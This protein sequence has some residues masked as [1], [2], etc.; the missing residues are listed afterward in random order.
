MKVA[1]YLGGLNRGGAES[2]ILDICRRKDFA[3]FDFV[4]LYRK[5]GNL[6]EG[7]HETKADVVK[8]SRNGNIIKYVYQLRKFFSKG[9][10]DVVHAQTPSSAMLCM[11]A[12]AFTNT[13]LIVTFHG[14][15]VGMKNW[16]LKWI[17]RHCVNVICVSEY[18]RQFFENRLDLPKMN[19]LRVVYNGIDFSK[20]ETAKSVKKDCI[21]DNGNVKLCMVGSFCTGRSQD[22]IVK[23]MALLK[24]RAK[25]D[26]VEFY[27]IG[28]A[29][30]GEEHEL[31]ACVKLADSYGLAGNVHFL[32]VRNDV[33]ELMK[34]MDGY[35][36][37]TVSDTF[38]ISLIEAMASGLPVLVNDWKV[39]KEV[40]GEWA[41]YF[42]SDDAEDCA[43][44]IE[45]FVENIQEYKENSKRY[46]DEV[47]GKY[48]I[49][50]HLKNIYDIYKS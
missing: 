7:F 47:I 16:Y 9:K 28:G 8:L 17:Y 33:Y 10:F 11:F 27:F 13:K 44:A 42:K 30:K 40:C 3:P 24:E 43:N 1:Y 18:E 25:C 38:G 46:I 20:I 5:E 6:S 19:K 15:Y 14:H 36:Y 39:M 32:G 22:V 48:S 26:N 4:C 23:S 37:S 50:R 45:N 21:A 49:E 2:L 31:E 41:N 29:F 34:H 35:V 12:L